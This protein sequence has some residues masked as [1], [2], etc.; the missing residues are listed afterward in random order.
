MYKWQHYYPMWLQ[1]FCTQFGFKVF[2]PWLQ[3]ASI[4]FFFWELQNKS[5][6]S[7]RWISKDRLCITLHV[8]KGRTF[9]FRS[10]M[11]AKCY[12]IGHKL[13]NSCS[14]RWYRHSEIL[15]SCDIHISN[16]R[17]QCCN[18]TLILSSHNLFCKD[19]VKREQ[20]AFWIRQTPNR[21]LVS[22]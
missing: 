16:H 17:L 13:H 19:W 22:H 9:G 7:G 5:P 18:I 1:T 6:F 3:I 15:G 21:W 2:N 8:N 4:V 20:W 10:W 11:P 14:A 12:V